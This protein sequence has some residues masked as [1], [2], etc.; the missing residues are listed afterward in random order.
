AAANPA[1]PLGAI[2]RLRD[3]ERSF[4]DTPWRA[5][6]A[7]LRVRLE[8][9]LDRKNREA[10]RAIVDRAEALVKEARHADALA[11]FDKPAPGLTAEGWPARLAAARAAVERDA[12]AAFAAALARGDALAAKGDPD[13]ALKAYEAAG[14]AVPDAWRAEAEPRIAEAR[15]QQKEALDRAAAERDAAQVR[16]LAELAELY[17]ARKY[18]EAALFLKSRIE[19]AAPADREELEREL[20]ET[21]RLQ[22]IWARILRG[23]EEAVGKPFVV[24]GIQGE[25]VA[26]QNGK[27]T[28]RTPGG[29]FTEDIRNFG[30]DQLL[31]LG[32]TQYSALDAPLA[33]AR[34]LAAEGKP[35]AVEARLKG[36]KAG[37]A[38]AAALRERMRRFDAAA[39]LAAAAKDLK[40]A[41]KL[42]AAGDAD[43]AAAALRAFL[44]RHGDL[45]A[46]GSLRAEAQRLLKQATA[47]KPATWGHVG[48]RA[49]ARPGANVTNAPDPTIYHTE[50]YGLSAYRIPLPNGSYL[51]RL[52]FAETFPGV[53]GVGQRVFSIAIEER[54]ALPDLDV[55]KEAARQRLAAV[56]FDFDIEVQDAELTIEFTPKLQA[57]MINAIEVLAKGRG[58]PRD[59]LLINCGATQ[60]YTDKAGRTWRKDQEYQP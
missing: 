3:V 5:R 35:E 17:R 4:R 31:A 45:P 33:A 57:A 12:R 23:T 37:D 16:T 27:A 7:V 18:P 1:D 34:F 20:A 32:L 52:H 15:R 53:T 29:S 49:V 14:A 10:L 47:P 42:L 43:G 13:G 9:E 58:R 11:L 24:R 38:E 30:A 26:V 40:D 21:A 22:D 46:A 8:G 51:V 54:Q 39:R 60:D 2:A 25:L 36:L 48:G 50:R 41:Q 6:A 28:I 44:T 19:A 56:S 55:V 59:A